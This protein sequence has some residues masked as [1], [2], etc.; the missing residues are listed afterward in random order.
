MKLSQISKKLWDQWVE[1]EIKA[2]VFHSSFWCELTAKTFNKRIMYYTAEYINDRY[3]MPIFFDETTGEYS[4]GFIGHGGPLLLKN[5]SSVLTQDTLIRLILELGKIFGK[6]P[7]KVILDIQNN[8]ADYQLQHYCCKIN[9]TQVL[10]ITKS[11]ESIF[12]KQISG[13]VRTAIRKAKKDNVY[14]LEEYCADDL[15][16]AH[17]LLTR[18]QIYVGSSYVIPYKLFKSLASSPLSSIFL[19]KKDNNII[20]V[21]VCLFFQRKAFFY[22]N[23]WDRSYSSSCP[24]QLLIWSMINEANARGCSTFNFGVS[25]SEALR[26]SKSRWGTSDF[27]V[28]NIERIGEN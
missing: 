18:T 27:F 19:A 10:D 2:N 12:E 5:T 23:G 11:I 13:N 4:I 8:A 25:H 1:K 7:K 21:S 6:F 9:K 24:N 3:L 15:L 17:E 22:L 16:R 26:R 14:I 28:I 20:A